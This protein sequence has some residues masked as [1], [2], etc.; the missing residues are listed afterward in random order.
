MTGRYFLYTT[1]GAAVWRLTAVSDEE[2]EPAEFFTPA[3]MAVCAGDAAADACAEETAGI[4]GAETVD[5]DKMAEETGE[6]G[7]VLEETVSVSGICPPILEH[8][9]KPPSK[10]AA[11]AT[12]AT[13]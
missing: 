2:M 9:V 10:I 11:A 8:P 13:V 5:D 12:A 6:D 7:T 1:A 4:S 3:D